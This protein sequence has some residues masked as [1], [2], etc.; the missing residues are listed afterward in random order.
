MISAP[1]K[2]SIIDCTRTRSKT[3]D[4]VQKEA[5]SDYERIDESIAFLA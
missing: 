1:N 3:C 2:T 5:T 4:A